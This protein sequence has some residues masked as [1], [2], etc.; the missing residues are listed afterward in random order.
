MLFDR[1]PPVHVAGVPRLFCSGMSW[2]RTVERM[3]SA[4]TSKFAAGNAPHLLKKGRDAGCIAAR[5]RSSCI[6]CAVASWE[7]RALLNA[8]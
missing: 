1:T 8:R 3:P 5:S 4:P 2:R 7:G 6:P